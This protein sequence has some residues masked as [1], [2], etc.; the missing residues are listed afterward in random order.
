MSV[1]PLTLTISLCLVFTFVLFFIREQG[2]RH[3]HSAESESLLPL[4]DETPRVV[5]ATTP[6]PAHAHAHDGAAHVCKNNGSCDGCQRR[7]ARQ[8]LKA[9]SI[10]PSSVQI[11][12]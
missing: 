12:G 8:A 5:P 6:A 9:A 11:T 10:S 4:A 1:I 7:A 2:R 3:L